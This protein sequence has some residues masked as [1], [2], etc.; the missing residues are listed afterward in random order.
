MK[1]F[2]AASA[3]C[4]LLAACG[5]NTTP[6]ETVAINVGSGSADMKVETDGDVVFAVALSDGYVMAPLA[7]RDVAAGY[8]IA[9]NPGPSARLVSASSPLAT[10]VELH[11][12]SMADGVMS[13]REVDGVD[14]PQGESVTF[15]PGGLHLMLFGFA[16]DAGVDEAPVT[17]TFEG[18]QT[19]DVVLP[20]RERG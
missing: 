4:L 14:L 5:N 18:G 7:G 8:F 2:F 13:M 10:E 17:L 19:M 16:R 1:R 20:I 12:H 9:S 11:T 6:D 3:F 15:E